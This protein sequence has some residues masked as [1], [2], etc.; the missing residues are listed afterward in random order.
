M[1]ALFALTAPFLI[2]NIGFANVA[3]PADS[4]E[5]YL[6][7]LKQKEFVYDYQKSE[8][9]SSMLRDSWIQPIIMR[10]SY[11]KSNPY[12]STQTVQN[13]AI[14][15]DQPIF[16]S[17]GIYFAIKY[18]HASRIYANYSIDVA[19]RKLIKDAV[20]LLMQIKKS[21]I[22]ISKHHLQVANAKINL[23]QKQELYMNG[24]L[25]SG[26]L[27]NAVIELNALKQALYDLETSKER[28]VS[29]FNSI[30]DLDYKNATIPHLKLVREEDFLTQSI[31][32]K[33]IQSENEK[34]RY[35]KNMT[36]AKYLPKLSVTAGY[37][38]DSLRNP[39][40]AGTAM[41]SPPNTSYYNYGFK[42]SMPLN[43]NFN[44]D[45]ESVKVE[46]FKSLVVLEDTKRSLIALYSQVDQNLRNY[47]KKIALANENSKL[48]EKLHVD[49]ISLFKAGYKTEYDVELLKNSLKIQDLDGEMFEIDKQLELLN[50]YEKM[51][52]EI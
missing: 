10:Y 15:L 1:R 22:S 29:S 18:A 47:D 32:I 42:V 11:K 25:D 43:I 9:Q 46:Y 20:S 16:Q 4:L 33:R 24:Q 45:I 51:V 26:F 41:P 14:V 36:I 21:G 3:Q 35:F 2:C 38:W 49:T 23:D 39:S 44:R 8:A 37:S 52:N 50:L 30:S 13:A 17:G 19:K 7:E 28:L 27:D 6:S 5:H 31:D 34:N 48:Y 40:F 12:D